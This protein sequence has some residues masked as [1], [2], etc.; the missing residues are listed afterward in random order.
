ML[1][2]IHRFHGWP[3]ITL[4]AIFSTVINIILVN[5]HALF[6]LVDSRVWNRLQNVEFKFP[7]F[8]VLG[9]TG[10]LTLWQKE[11]KTAN[12][13]GGL[14]HCTAFENSWK[15][16]HSQQRILLFIPKDACGESR[17][18]VR[19]WRECSALP[20]NLS[21]RSPSTHRLPQVSLG[22][23]TWFRKHLI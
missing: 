3:G 1:R 6:K 23:S 22:T 16:N 8:S 17:K 15:M 14:K 11:R 12:S 5:C 18:P 2:S 7:K 19:P 4:E 13:Y 21:T 20:R 9:Q 10:S